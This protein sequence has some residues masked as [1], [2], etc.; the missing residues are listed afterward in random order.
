MPRT[1]FLRVAVTVVTATLIAGCSSV[2]ELLARDDESG[3]PTAKIVVL[4]PQESGRAGAEVLAA[5]QLAVEDG[6]PMAPGWTLSV[7]GVDVSDAAA[8]ADELTADD[9][10]LAVVG[11]LTGQDLRAVLPALAGASILFV[12]PNDVA[13]EHTRGADPTT[14]LRPYPSYFRTTVA[15][16]DAI[17]TAAEY[18]VEGLNVQKV[19]VVHG[20]GSDEAVR[21]AAEVRR[22]GVKIVASGPAG[23]DGAGIAKVIAASVSG[24]ADVVY[25][26]GEASVA[27]QVAKSLAR[28]GLAAH[29]IGGA[30][31]HSNE[32]LTAAGTAADGALAVVPPTRQGDPVGTASDLTARLTER[33]IITPS[34]LAAAAY[35]A[36]SALAAAFSRCLPPQDSTVEARDPCV[37]EMQHVIFSGLTGD[38]AFDAYGDRIGTRP[39][40]YQVR[41]GVWTEVGGS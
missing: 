35:D 34:P 13:P 30:A 29:L 25:T 26:A 41:D 3:H 1:V 8:T 12:S 39:L 38:V 31:L 17:T 19:A 18:A 5:V 40:V 37:A 2:G 27:A 24:Q 21:F 10:V 11:G 22:R 33:G 9:D 16:G 7:V 23:A 4:T 20:G 28:A 6:A 14:P 36:G 32:F 15:G